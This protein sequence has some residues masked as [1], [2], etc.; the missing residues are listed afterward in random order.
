MQ[1]NLKVFGQLTDIININELNIQSGNDTDSLRKELNTLFPGLAGRN[2][3]MAVDQRTTT[4]N[5]I[6]NEGSTVA[7]MP[8]FSGG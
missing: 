3:L 8:P 2:F 1:I 6:L 4:G 7:L 5:T